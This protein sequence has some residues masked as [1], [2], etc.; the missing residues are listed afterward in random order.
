[1]KPRTRTAVGYALL[2]ALPVG[3]GLGVAVEVMGGSEGLAVLSGVVAA[4]VLFVVLV[5]VFATG[6]TDRGA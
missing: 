6:A 4:V 3:A 1:M 5:G 2:F